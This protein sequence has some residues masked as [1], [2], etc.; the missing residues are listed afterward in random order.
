[1]NSRLFLA[2]S[3]SFESLDMKVGGG[4]KAYRFQNDAAARLYQ[5][6]IQAYLHYFLPTSGTDSGETIFATRFLRSASGSWT[7]W[8][9]ASFFY[10]TATE[11]WLHQHEYCIDASGRISSD[12]V[13]IRLGH[14]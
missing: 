5:K 2:R 6:T 9:L 12:P 13:M 11:L 4:E 10:A 1:M 14:S 7:G 3:H 8:K